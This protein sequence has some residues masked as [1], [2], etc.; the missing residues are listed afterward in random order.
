MK[1]LENLEREEYS[2]IVETN[3]ILPGY[4]KKY[5][6]ELA[7]F[8]FVHVRVSIKGCNE[9]EFILVT[10][11]KPEGFLL[12]FKALKN[13]LNSNVKCHASVMASFSPHDAII[14][15][16]NRFQEL[17]IELAE[18]LE[19]EELIVYTCEKKTRGTQSKV[20]FSIFA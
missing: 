10:G 7:L 11:A 1:L 2:F 12:Q 3:G 4:D 19:I 18:N 15:L 20:L 16:R 13:L 8:K 6:E 9:S 5:A 14:K 17:N